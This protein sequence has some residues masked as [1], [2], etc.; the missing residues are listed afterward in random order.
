MRDSAFN[1]RANRETCS[2]KL[3]ALVVEGSLIALKTF[4]LN[5]TRNLTNRIWLS[6]VAKFVLQK[7]QPAEEN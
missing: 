2:V 6:N 1:C 3:F 7:L 4:S 5:Y